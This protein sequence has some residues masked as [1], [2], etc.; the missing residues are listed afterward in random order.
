MKTANQPLYAFAKQIQW[1]WQEKY[2][3]DNKLVIMFGGLHI[4]MTTEIDW[5]VT[6]RQW[7]DKCTC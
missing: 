2:G 4:G 5:H 3:E 1:H 6:Q 7:M